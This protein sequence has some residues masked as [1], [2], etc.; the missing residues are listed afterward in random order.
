MAVTLFLLVMLELLVPQLLMLVPTETISFFSL[1]L[2]GATVTVATVVTLG[3]VASVSVVVVTVVNVAGVTAAIFAAE[4][5]SA[6]GC[7]A[8]THQP[9][10]GAMGGTVGRRRAVRTASCPCHRSAR[11]RGTHGDRAGRFSRD[12]SIS[13]GVCDRV[14]VLVRLRRRYS[15]RSTLLVAPVVLALFRR[16]FLFGR[17]RLRFQV[18]SGLDIYMYA[19]EGWGEGE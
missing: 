14:P 6:C 2:G 3:V 10:C 16:C 19:R 4:A 12:V 5:A 8:V 7:R 15:L 1:P 13:T 18:S 9:I 17:G 11:C